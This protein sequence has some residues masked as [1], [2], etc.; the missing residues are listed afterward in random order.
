MLQG[1]NILLGVTGGIAAYKSCELVRL[2][3]K[4]GAR[5]AVVMTRSAT[6]LV[7]PLTF[8]VLSEN[9]VLTDLWQA[10]SQAV[11][12]EP[13]AG[14]PSGPVAHVD[15]G[16]FADLV[17]VAPATA[18]ILAK[19]AHGL[20]DDALSTV[21][22]AARAPVMFAPTMNVTMWDSAAVQE[23]LATL[24]RRGARIVE[25]GEGMLACGWEGKGR[26]AEPAEIVEFAERVLA[27]GGSAGDVATSRGAA[28][29]QAAPDTAPTPLAPR[30]DARGVAPAAATVP[31]AAWPAAVAGATLSGRAVLVSAGP[32]QEPID[33]VRYLSNRSSGKMGY[34]VA[35][36]ARDLGARVILVSGPTALPCPAGVERVD[37]VTAAEMEREV[38]GRGA[39]AD[40]IVMTAAVSDYR[41]A[42][43]SAGKL[44][45]AGA[46]TLE[47]VPNDDI[48]AKLGQ[49]KKGRFLVGFALEVESCIANAEGKLKNKKADLVVLNNPLEPGAAFGSDTNHVTILE[50]GREPDVWPM[51]GKSEVAMRLMGLVGERLPR[52]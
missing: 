22:L 8:Q 42:E 9:P 4:R 36:A 1:R 43:P 46:R 21:L 40:V 16:A 14:L 37:V 44:K 17:I 31:G 38:L 3:K 6:R 41:P 24:R 48:L 39:A 30:V 11:D 18:N 20:G 47:L 45:R 52:R 50:P 27:E 23:N 12:F 25:P 28:A 19:A 10:P 26:M 13:R 34:A 33:A 5:V 2:L 51:L 29:G 35:E 49:D 32:T 7:Q 15:L